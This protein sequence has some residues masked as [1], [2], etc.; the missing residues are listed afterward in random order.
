MSWARGS[1]GLP[2]ETIVNRPSNVMLPRLAALVAAAALIVAPACRRAAGPRDAGFGDGRL[3]LSGSSTVA[4]LV[5]EIA[6]RFEA[7]HPGVR[8]DVQTGGSS[9]GVADAR[10]RT[11]Q[12]G[13]VSRALSAE[14]TDLTASRIAMDGVAMIVHASNPIA[15]LSN[16]QIVDI[17]T[18][19]ITNWSA[20]GGKDAPITV[21]NKAEGR[22]TLELFAS[23][24]TI[25]R[26]AIKASVV[27]GENLHGVRTV[28][29][30]PNAIGYVSVGTAEHERSAG[31]PIRMLPLGGVEPSTAT[32][33]DG[34]FPLARPLNLVTTGQR[35]PLVAAF[36]ALA[37]SAEVTDLVQGQ[38]FV[39]IAE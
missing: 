14:E 29:D 39:P 18:G 19:A 5:G 20:V 11:V 10:R 35:S 16:Q 32:V 13:M 36:V 3:T 26:T 37:T 17:Y 23:H 21:V 24:F 1:A 9:R 12:I 2:V 34:S 31:V 33:R 4:P 15:T 22:S 27:I 28:A 7:K 25:D 6:K 30:D 38:F 8:V